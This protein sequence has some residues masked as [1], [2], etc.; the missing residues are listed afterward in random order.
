M[1]SLLDDFSDE[2]VP[3]VVGVGTGGSSPALAAHLRERVAD[4]VGGAGAMA[5]LRDRLAERGVPAGRRRAARRAV[6]GD[7][8]VWTALDTGTA[9]ARVL[10]ET[11][12]SDVTGE[13]S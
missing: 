1:I 11:V 3:I 12:I 7:D 13:T 8:A 2:T 6:V 10:A 9:N 5:D 4:D